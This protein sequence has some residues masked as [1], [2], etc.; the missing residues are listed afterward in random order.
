MTTAVL[1]IINTSRTRS[2]V[3]CSKMAP[4]KVMQL[5]TSIQR[6]INLDS[7]STNS[8][9]L[10]PVAQRQPLSTV[11]Y[12]YLFAS[13]TGVTCNATRWIWP[14]G[15]C[16]DMQIHSRL[17]VPMIL[18]HAPANTY[19]QPQI[20]DNQMCVCVCVCVVVLT[21]KYVEPN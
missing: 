7:S 4:R 21:L 1:F 14:T 11:H 8:A 18:K 3:E 2:G 6:T 19:N 13:V 10:S 15:H 9:C 17:C 5:I 12:L 20:N 16:L